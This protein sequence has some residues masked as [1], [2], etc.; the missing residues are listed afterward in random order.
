MR[1]VTF[2]SISFNLGTLHCY[3]HIAQCSGQKFGQ[4]LGIHNY[5]NNIA[6]LLGHMMLK[7]VMMKILILMMKI[8]KMLITMYM[9]M[10]MM[11]KI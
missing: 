5:S 9:M 2:L 8:M 4:R 11:M 1:S 10:M 6:T 3:G 7:A